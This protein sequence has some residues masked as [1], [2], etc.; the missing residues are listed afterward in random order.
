MPSIGVTCQKSTNQRAREINMNVNIH[1]ALCASNQF[2]MAEA[3][4][5]K[6]IVKEK[7]L[8][9]EVQIIIVDALK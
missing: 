4:T 3:E 5:P 8:Q 7:S 9:Q 2:T 6:K 1:N